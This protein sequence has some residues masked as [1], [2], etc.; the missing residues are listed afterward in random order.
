MLRLPT[1]CT[2]ESKMGL[3][4][5]GCRFRSCIGIL[6]VPGTKARKVMKVGKREKN[7]ANL[8]KASE[9]IPARGFAEIFDSLQV[10]SPEPHRSVLFQGRFVLNPMRE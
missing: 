9:R 3:S 7:L 10:P 1:E 5:A 4:L 6:C 2:L 8:R